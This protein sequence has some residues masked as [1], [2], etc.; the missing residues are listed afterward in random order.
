MLSRLPSTY[1]EW[2]PDPNS[3]KHETYLKDASFQT[4]RLEKTSRRTGYFTALDDLPL[5][6][7][8]S[9]SIRLGDDF[10]KVPKLNEASTNWV[11]YKDRLLWLITSM[12]L[13][14]HLLNRLT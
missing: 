5:P 13:V 14:Q 12:G 7:T 6:I 3:V 2:R 10:M 11:V 9:V 8:M 1:L 4:W